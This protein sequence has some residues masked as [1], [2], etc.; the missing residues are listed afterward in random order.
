PAGPRRFLGRW[1]RS[2]V[3]RILTCRTYLGE[4]R[5]GGRARGKYARLT[6]G[7]IGDP[8]AA[9]AVEEV[10]VE[11]AHPA[12]IDIGLL[13][14]CRRGAQRRGFGK[15]ASGQASRN[16]PF[17]GLVICGHCGRRMHGWTLRSQ[18]GG[19]GSKVYRYRRYVCPDAHRGGGQSCGPAGIAEGELID[20]VV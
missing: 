15:R 18:P 9:G 12:I 20:A 1:D 4:L 14:D 2:V 13:R 11:A 16:Y 19:A 17:S 3:G 10:V 5:W 8:Q 6:G 7:E